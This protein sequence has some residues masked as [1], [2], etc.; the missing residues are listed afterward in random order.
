MLKLRLIAENPDLLERFEIV[1]ITPNTSIVV[2]RPM[3]AVGATTL[4][5]RSLKTGTALLKGWAVTG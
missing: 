3:A 4:T 1:S 5:F 2:S